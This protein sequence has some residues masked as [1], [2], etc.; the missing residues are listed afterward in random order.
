[1]V[2][3]H[4]N[5]LACAHKQQRPIACGREA[6]TL[7]ALA[8]VS[9]RGTPPLTRSKHLPGSRARRRLPATFIIRLVAADVT[10]TRFHAFDKNEK[11]GNGCRR[12]MIA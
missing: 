9:F 2:L 3:Q 4:P 5:E 1:L 10:R 8:Q 11:G 7:E 6:T 12:R